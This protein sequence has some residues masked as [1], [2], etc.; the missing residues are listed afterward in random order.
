MFT[1]G[2]FYF[3]PPNRYIFPGAEVFDD[4]D[5]S[6][7]STRSNFGDC[8]SDDDDNDANAD[9]DDKDVDDE[10]ASSQSNSTDENSTI[11]LQTNPANDQ[12]SV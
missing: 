2:A 11:A 5:D 7:N 1:D 3:F 9:D 4:H 8:S 10:P 12:H 6:T